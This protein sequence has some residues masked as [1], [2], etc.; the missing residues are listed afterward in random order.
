MALRLIIGSFPLPD[1]DVVSDDGGILRAV[2]TA[3]LHIFLNNRVL[4]QNCAD[5]VSS[6][7]NDGAGQQDGVFND[8]ALADH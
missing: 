5:N 1:H 6:C 7:F 3:K 4:S 2:N 8:S